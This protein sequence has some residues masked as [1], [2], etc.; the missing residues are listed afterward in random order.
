MTS[1]GYFLRFFEDCLTLQ[2]QHVR[3]VISPERLDFAF[4]HLF[5]LT[6]H[7]HGHVLESRQRLHL[8]HQHQHDLSAAIP[9]D[10]QPPVKFF[11]DVQLQKVSLDQDVVH[12]P[13]LAQ[14]RAYAL[15]NRPKP[16]SYTHLT[17]PTTPYV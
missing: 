3:D 8:L 14:L 17:L 1:M 6:V 16:V 13:A 15:D 9:I 4:D 12:D 5:V 10:R 11:G 2:I 7:S